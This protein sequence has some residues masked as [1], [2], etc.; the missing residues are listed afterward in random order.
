MKKMKPPEVKA[1]IW[2]DQETA[3]IIRFAGEEEPVMSRIKSDV[4]SR[5]R[6]AGEGKV[7]AR[8]GN[9][10]IDDQEKKQRRQRNERKV[11]FKEIIERIRDVDYL[12]IFGPGRAKEE[13][14]NAIEAASGLKAKVICIEPADKITKSRMMMKVADY[15]NSDAFRLFKKNLRKQKA[16][17]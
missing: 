13:F 16:L 7:S 12:M 10:F 9:A 3:Y 14:N 4:E 8:F 17:A 11:Y 15:F 5:I 1:G 2:I 6:V